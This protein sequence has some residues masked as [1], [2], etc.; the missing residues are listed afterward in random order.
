MAR[1]KEIFQKITLQDQLISSEKRKIVEIPFLKPKFVL[2]YLLHRFD[3]ISQPELEQLA[4]VLYRNSQTNISTPLLQVIAETSI[5]E[6]KTTQLLKDKRA[7]NYH[8]SSPVEKRLKAKGIK[9]FQEDP[10]LNLVALHYEK[11]EMEY[12]RPKE[13][14]RTLTDAIRYDPDPML[15]EGSI[16]PLM[17]DLNSLRTIGFATDRHNGT[18]IMCFPTKRGISFADAIL[19]SFVHVDWRDYQNP[20]IVVKSSGAELYDRPLP[21][22]KFFGKK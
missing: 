9:Q 19:N 10:V 8:S 22:P 3:N 5:L 12:Q 1:E 15:G 11:E 7:H 2:L 16:R 4:D 14:P 13:I 21:P 20:L 18:D 17:H 6:R